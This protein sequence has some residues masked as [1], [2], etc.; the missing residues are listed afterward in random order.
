MTTP[1]PI[2]EDMLPRVEMG[3]DGLPY[4]A[5][6]PSKSSPTTAPYI[7]ERSI[8]GRWMHIDSRCPGWTN[9]GKCYHVDALGALNMTMEQE[10]TT[11]VT[12]SVLAQ[13]DALDEQQVIARLTGG[14][15]EVTQKWVYSFPGVV[16]LSID[17]VQEAARHLATQG[18][19]IEQVWVHMDDQNEN[20]AFFT[21]CAVR[22]AVSPTG[23]RVELDRAIRAKRQPKFTKLRNGGT[24]A[25]EFWY[26]VGVA[27][28]LRNAVE[29]LLPEAIKAHMIKAAGQK[30]VQ[31]TP[32][33]RQAAQHR[34]APTDGRKTQP[35]AKTNGN[36][37]GEGAAKQRVVDL[38]KRA[39]NEIDGES[40]K[41][42]GDGIRTRWPEAMG[43]N[44][45]LTLSNTGADIAT[46]I[47]DYVLTAIEGEGPAQGAFD[48][49]GHEQQ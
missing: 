6:I 30:V 28:A 9:N 10:Q 41:A 44:G 45:S 1:T 43:A 32:A 31:A 11:A 13:I 23:Q 24:Q 34:T 16:G 37:N 12:V 48:E 40:F 42:M 38:I 21:A 20:E 15:P 3:P 47:G 35:A 49:T 2:R 22:Y 5:S 19:A 29:A 27:K 8:A 14:L 18:E 39:G 26:E 17:G 46:A 36:G 4:R 25:N 7:L 33:Q